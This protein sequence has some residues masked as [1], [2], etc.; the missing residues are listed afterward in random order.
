M[1]NNILI[2]VSCPVVWPED[3]TNEEAIEWREGGGAEEGPS[4]PQPSHL[5]LA[6]SA[7][8]W[9]G[10]GRTEAEGKEADT[11]KGQFISFHSRQGMV[12]ERLGRRLGRRL[13]GP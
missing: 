9:V 5:S 13:E 4:G 6:A 12:E 11:A 1:N 3:G 7:T 8:E 2:N 10:E